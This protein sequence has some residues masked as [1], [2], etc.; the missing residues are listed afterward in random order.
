MREELKVEIGEI[1]GANEIAAPNADQA[2]KKNAA[3]TTDN[4]AS[5]KDTRDYFELVYQCIHHRKNF[6]NIFTLNSR[7]P[8]ENDFDLFILKALLNGK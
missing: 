6:L 3:T 4:K 7:N 5:S 2:L 1:R 8:V